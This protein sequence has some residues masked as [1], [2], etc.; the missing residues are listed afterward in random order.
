[1][2]GL[3]P[4]P[5]TEGK[6]PGRCASNRGAYSPAV[7]ACTWCSASRLPEARG[8]ACANA[9]C[10]SYASYRSG[11]SSF[12]ACGHPPAWG[13]PGGAVHS[14]VLFTARLAATPQCQ[15]SCQIAAT[16]LVGQQIDPAACP[17]NRPCCCN[18][19]SRSRVTCCLCS[20]LEV[21]P[22]CIAFSA[23]PGAPTQTGGTGH[24]TREEARAGATAPVVQRHRGGPN[25]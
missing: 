22:R 4:A 20:K 23:M 9:T 25:F 12:S 8:R 19:R 10:A 24:C 18:P 16:P 7:F 14:C 3:R 11:S 21:G 5:T 2:C 1:M 13:R 15:S 17:I 6:Q